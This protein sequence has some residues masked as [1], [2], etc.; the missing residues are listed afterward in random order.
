MYFEKPI[1]MDCKSKWHVIITYYG[2]LLLS[3]ATFAAC[4]VCERFLFFL[5]VIGTC[6]C[7][8]WNNFVIETK[9]ME[10]EMDA[11]NKIKFC[12][13]RKLCNMKGNKAIE[14]FA[15]EANFHWW[16]TFSGCSYCRNDIHFIENTILPKNKKLNKI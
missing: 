5:P 10:M 2:L 6:E 8:T 3:L 9:W 7:E 15:N 12:Q 1:T 16:I 4:N 13:K 11:D 14:C